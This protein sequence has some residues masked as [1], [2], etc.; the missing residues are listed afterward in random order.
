ML[1]GTTGTK[2]K[3][4]F[5]RW[6]CQG[7]EIDGV[8]SWSATALLVYSPLHAA[9]NGAIY[10]NFGPCRIHLGANSAPLQ[11]TVGADDDDDDNAEDENDDNDDIIIPFFSR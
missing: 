6:L 7:C 9:L 3:G 4:R 2:A 8:H 5:A 10:Q 11:A 1:L